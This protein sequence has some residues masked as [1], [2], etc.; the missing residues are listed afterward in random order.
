MCLALLRHILGVGA[1]RAVLQQEVALFLEIC[2]LFLLP[3]LVS[4]IHIEVRL[5]LSFGHLSPL[6]TCHRHEMSLL[7]VR[8]SLAEFLDVAIAEVDVR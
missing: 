7:L 2:N 5:L 4:R 8:M 3:N 6:Q 1:F